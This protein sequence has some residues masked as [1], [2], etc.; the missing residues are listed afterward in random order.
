MIKLCQSYHIS[1][2]TL[3]PDPLARA[4]LI[5]NIVSEIGASSNVFGSL[6]STNHII[7]VFDAFF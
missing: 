5:N 3:G 1:L 7:Y 6:Y 4:A 2:Y